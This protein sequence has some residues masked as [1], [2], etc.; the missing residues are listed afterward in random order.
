MS[1][2]ILLLLLALIVF[3][4]LVFDKGRWSVNLMALGMAFFVAAFLSELL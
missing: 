2:T 1:I 4:L 3:V